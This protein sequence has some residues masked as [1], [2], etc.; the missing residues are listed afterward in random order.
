MANARLINAVT[1]RQWPYRDNHP[2][3]AK[4]GAIGWRAD[5]RRTLTPCSRCA[6]VFPCCCR[7]VPRCTRLSRAL[8]AHPFLR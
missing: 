3:A 4:R 8:R 5:A 1:R 6:L 2:L 7:Y